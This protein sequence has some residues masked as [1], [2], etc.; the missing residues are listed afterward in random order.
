MSLMDESILREFL[1]ESLE[2]VEQIERELVALEREP[3]DPKR[4][5]TLFRAVH[6]IKGTCG[7]FGFTKL[8]GITHAGENLLG[9]L[10]SGELTLTPNIANALLSLVDALRVILGRIEA[11]QTEGDESFP[12]LIE[13]LNQLDAGA[14]DG[15]TTEADAK[16]ENA[17]AT[18]TATSVTTPVPE[19]APDGTPPTSPT[20]ATAPTGATPAAP[21][22]SPGIV[23]PDGGLFAPL[24]ASG[25]LDAKALARAAEQQRQ[26][27]PRRM[28]EILVEH[29]ALEPQDV[30]DALLARSE[31][32]AQAVSDTIVRVD[33]HL[34]DHLMNLVGELVLARNQLLLEVASNDLDELPATAQRLNHVTTELQERIMKTRM[35]PIGTLCNKLPRLVR[36]TAAACEKKVRLE[37]EGT[38]TELDR[39]ILDAMR[40]PLTHLVR[41]AIDHG[42][43]TPDE[44]VARGKPA[45]GRLSIRAF[46]EGGKVH[47]E[48][49]DDGGGILIERLR[50]RALRLHL[51]P[52][53]RAPHMTDRDWANVIFMP[54][55]STADR[56]TGISGRGV[57][58]DVV[59]T[60]VE[61]IG[62]TI[63]VDSAP[64][65]GTTM[66]IRIPLT[67][68]I[69][70]ALIVTAGGERYAI[71]QVNLVELIRVERTEFE[72]RVPNAFDAPVLRYRDGL[73]PLLN[74]GEVLH[75][76]APAQA[77]DAA[78]IAVLHADGV[79][80][81]L[82][83]DTIEASQEIVVKPLGEPLR[84]IS[85]FAGATILGDGAVALILDVPGLARQAGLAVRAA[86]ALVPSS[87][88]VDHLAGREH[89]S[90]RTLVLCRAG[91]RW[92]V[93]IPQEQIARLEE[94]PRRLLETIGDRAA[95]QYRGGILPLVSLGAVLDLADSP[96]AGDAEWIGAQDPLPV[97]VHEHE[98]R[99]L[100]LVVDSIL[101]IVDARVAAGSRRDRAGFGGAVVVRGSVTELLDLEEL[102]AAS[103]AGRDF[104]LARTGTEG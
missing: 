96:R 74:L 22:R 39:T 70:P 79:T 38:E 93:A 78:S 23:P 43:E 65:Q 40:D 48:V 86:A 27:D 12:R 24:V 47:V 52:L 1:A 20:P 25:R 68:A 69:V 72:A 85:V 81:G 71:P 2:N 37:M 60:N 100:G 10:R 82:V 104:T 14:A 36:D 102:L 30:V 19:A 80:V 75:A 9:R 94:I 21:E 59:K 77:G 5:G 34:L 54:G 17:A 61:S 3:G 56:V 99:T 73:L 64:G 63:D 42:I 88:D 95:V 53:D 103:P 13:W 90:A 7:F 97:V 67:L 32:A 66:R 58:M 87:E 29:G 16:A 101:E 98:G 8:A 83:V 50:E 44:R 35:Q 76:A 26:G 41:N 6:S 55:F 4:I 15:G 92:T 28:G 11:T 84:Q 46:H 57:G 89:F 91:A 51:V 62:G 33:V 18:T 45:E 49:S 31:A